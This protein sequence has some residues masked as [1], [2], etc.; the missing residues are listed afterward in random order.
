M[1]SEPPA[2]AF[3]QGGP[4]T[5]VLRLEHRFILR[6]LAVLERVGRRLAYERRMDEAAARELVELLRVLDRSHHAKEE[7][8][9]FP[10]LR[11]KRLPEASPIA[12]MLAEH[13]EGRDYLVT[14]GGFEPAATRAAA[15]LLCVTTLRE[16]MRKE[17]ESL[18]PAVDA[19]LSPPEHAALA[20]RYEEVEPRLVGPRADPTVAERL[21]RLEAAFPA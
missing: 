7:D 1:G 3:Y 8:Y 12:V 16:H 15:A 19:L 14:L 18:F 21:A 11:Q 10:A 9:L 6:A 20:R 13:Q 4:A 17:D 2:L 5:A